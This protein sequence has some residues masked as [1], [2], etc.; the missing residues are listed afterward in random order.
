MGADP[1]VVAAS[2]FDVGAAGD[3]V[4]GVAVPLAAEHRPERGA[5][6]VGDDEPLALDRRRSC[7]Q[8]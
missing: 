3:A 5:H 2:D 7:R 8:W 4:D 1:G 6:A